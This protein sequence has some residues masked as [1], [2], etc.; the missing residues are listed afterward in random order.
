MYIPRSCTKFNNLS[1]ALQVQDRFRLL[2]WI[3]DNGNALGV[4]IRILPLVALRHVVLEC[5]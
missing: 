2:L 5:W 1:V 4:V 3:K